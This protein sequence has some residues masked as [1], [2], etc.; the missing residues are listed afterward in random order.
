MP[1]LVFKGVKVEEVKALSTQLVDTLAG[2]ANAPRHVFTLECVENAFIYDGEIVTP[3]PV[4]QVQ[5]IERGQ[6]VRDQMATA[7][8]QAV[9]SKGYDHVEIIFSELKKGDYYID[10]KVY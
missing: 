4:I 2:I 6:V 5:W 7:I 9:R 8:D 10:A 1:K 3:A